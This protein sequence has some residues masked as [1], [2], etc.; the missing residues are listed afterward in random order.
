VDGRDTN[1]APLT[2][3]DGLHEAGMIVAVV[4]RQTGLHVLEWKLR[5]NGDAVKRLLTVHG[6]V[7]AEFFERLAWKCLVD[8][9]GLLQTHDVELGRGEPSHQVFDALLDRVDV[10]SRDSHDSVNFS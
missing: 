9:L 3:D 4:P 7:V 6:D 8:S 1:D 2:G 5:Q 10:P